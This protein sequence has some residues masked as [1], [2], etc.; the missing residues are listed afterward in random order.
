MATTD[1]QRERSAPVGVVDTGE[2][3]SVGDAKATIS[4]GVIA[5]LLVCLL[6]AFLVALVGFLTDRYAV[7]VVG[8]AAVAAATFTWV[9]VAAV[10]LVKDGAVNF[11]VRR[12]FRRSRPGG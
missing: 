10:E 4:G 5:A 2:L 9:V 7:L 1:T 11:V 12:L 8:A 6:A 3:E